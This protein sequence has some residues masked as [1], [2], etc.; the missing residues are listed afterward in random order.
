MS[1]ISVEQVNNMEIVEI[2]IYLRNLPIENSHTK[3]PLFPQ[4]IPKISSFKQFVSIKMH[5]LVE[6][7]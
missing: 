6:I 5:K 2:R 4:I 1:S 3:E 7:K